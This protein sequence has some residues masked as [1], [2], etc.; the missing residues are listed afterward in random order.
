MPSVL[1]EIKDYSCKKIVILES[2]DTETINSIEEY[3]CKLEILDPYAKFEFQDNKCFDLSINLPF[4]STIYTFSKIS[5][6]SIFYL[7]NKFYFNYKNLPHNLIIGKKNL[8]SLIIELK[9]N[10]N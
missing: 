10:N 5:K 3:N 9:N 8:L 6:M 7:P 2:I 1:E 4:T